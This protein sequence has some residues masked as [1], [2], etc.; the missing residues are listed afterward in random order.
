MYESEGAGGLDKYYCMVGEQ[1]FLTKIEK[2]NIILT[3]YNVH[4]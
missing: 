3:L 1:E 2:K 4:V